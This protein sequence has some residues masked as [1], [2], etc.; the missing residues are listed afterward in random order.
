[1]P[2][3]IWAYMPASFGLS[4]RVLNS[5]TR[6]YSTWLAMSFGGEEKVPE[7]VATGESRTRIRKPSVCSSM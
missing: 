1:M 6:M 5:R 2:T 4:L 7:L 3:S